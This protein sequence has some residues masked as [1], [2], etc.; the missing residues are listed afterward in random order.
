M[1]KKKLLPMYNTTME[2][3][4]SASRFSKSKEAQFRL[5]VI[6]FSK[7]Y[8]VRLAQDV[9]SVSRTTI[10]RWKRCLKESVGKLDSLIPKSTRPR[11]VRTMKVNSK[12]ITFIRDIRETSK[13]RQREDKTIT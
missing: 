13:N 8:G 2:R 9:F 1:L 10:F 7:K 5:R 4:I 11:R 6:D 3:L 12:I